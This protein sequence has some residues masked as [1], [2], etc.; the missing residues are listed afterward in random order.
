MTDR[1]YKR[2]FNIDIKNYTKDTL[3]DLGIFIHF[4]ETNLLNAKILII[5]PEDTPYEGGYYIYKVRF[6]G[7]Y[8]FKPPKV[9]F[10]SNSKIRIHPNMYVNGKVCLSILGTWAGPSWESVMDINCVAKTIQSLMCKRALQNEPGFL[11]EEGEPCINYDRIISFE[12]INA[13]IGN[14]VQRAKLDKNSNIERLYGFHSIILE[15]FYKNKEE[16]L[17]RIKN[18]ERYICKPEEVNVSV[19]NIKCDE[20]YKK[21]FRHIGKIE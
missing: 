8:P 6:P 11:T 7:S 4:D 21:L 16:I 5:G 1:V 9:T 10:C 17:K 19:Y 20:D 12:N 2:I 3:D 13:Y 15:H 14:Q 18:N